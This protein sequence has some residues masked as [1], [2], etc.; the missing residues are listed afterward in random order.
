M[1]AKYGIRGF[2]TVKFFGE[3]KNAP[4]NYNGGRTANAVID[5]MFN[6]A[7]AIVNARTGGSQRSSSSSSSSTG[8]KGKASSDKDVIVLDDKN[9]DQTVYS[10]N[11]MWIVEFY[12][13]WCG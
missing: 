3:N 12:A 6:Q 10:S 1:G 7:K 11:D 13:P 4:T 2:P 8:S 5:F 9:F